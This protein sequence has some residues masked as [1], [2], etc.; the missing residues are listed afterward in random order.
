MLFRSVSDI[1]YRLMCG[2]AERKPIPQND[3]RPIVVA[4]EM[5]YGHLRAAHTLAESFHTNVVRMD[6]PPVAGPSEA[7]IWREV[8][9]FY[10]ALSRAVDWPLIGLAVQWMLEKITNILPLCPEGKVEPASFLTRCVDRLTR[11]VLGQR[12]RALATDTGKPILATYP[13]A[14]LAARHVPGV[15]VFCLATDT[16]LNRAWAPAD[17][18]RSGIHYFAPVSRVSDR[19]R[20]FGL[21]DGSI[22]LTGF[23][24][25]ARLV[26]EAPLS[27]RRRLIRL[28]PQSAFRSGTNE[29]AAS[30]LQDPIPETFRGP[31]VMAVAIGGAGAQIHHAN[32]I[33]QSLRKLIVDGELRLILVA[34]TNA[35]VAHHFRK[36][37]AMAGLENFCGAGVQI[38]FSSDPGNYFS[39][40]ED[41]IAE[42]DL[43]WT[44]PSELVFY[45]ALGLPVLLSPPVG[46]Q[47]RANRD[48]LLSNESALDAGSP[49]EFGQRL[50][51]LLAN[52]DLCRIAWNAY[53]RLDRNGLDRIH[54]VVHAIAENQITG[55]SVQG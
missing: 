16:D 10:N 54:Q 42:A 13:V 12:L 38:L 34:G 45:A 46:C 9:T 33:I 25:S 1:I 55:K 23:P 19:L 6:L 28:D 30:L 29:T 31:I 39:L 32:Q 11:T 4:V 22:H 7:V 14:A 35:E 51:T 43:L 48:W 3:S 20:S 50:D 15:H 18:G 52:G 17:A 53:S 47:E 2:K 24:L 40:F 5:G 36:M 26:A 21:S 27:L 41:C 44:K 49:A 8:R 37:L